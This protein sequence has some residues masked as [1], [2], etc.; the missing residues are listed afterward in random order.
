MAERESRPWVSAFFK[1]GLYVTVTTEQLVLGG[2]VPVVCRMSS[3]WHEVKHVISLPLHI[4]HHVGLLMA[5]DY[6]K[7]ERLNQWLTDYG[8]HVPS[9]RI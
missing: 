2:H 8:S 3:E 1:G 7:L 4:L 5:L 9:T 6:E